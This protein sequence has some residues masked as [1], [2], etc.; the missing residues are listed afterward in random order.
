MAKVE[1][2]V[3]DP[4]DREG[5]IDLQ[6]PQ[7]GEDLVRGGE[8]DLG[9]PAEDLVPLRDVSLVQLVVRLHRR[10]GD[11]VELVH[12]RPQRPR[13]DLLEPVYERGHE[14][15]AYPPSQKRSC[16]K[17]PPRWPSNCP[18]CPTRTTRSSRTSMPR[19]CASTTTCTTAPT[20]RTRT[21]R[22]RGR[23]WPTPRS[24]ACSRTSATSPTT[25]RPWCATTPAATRTIRCSGRS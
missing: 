13:C 10:A 2:V 19:R 14:R 4:A 15:G 25:S 12:L 17:E 21:P 5:Q 23:R 24:R 6:R 9:E 1:L 8:V 20:S 22:S 3:L 18:I 7:L 16:R 11:P